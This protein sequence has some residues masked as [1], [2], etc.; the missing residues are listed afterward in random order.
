MSVEQ[1]VVAYYGW[2]VPT[3]KAIF[4]WADELDYDLPDGVRLLNMD[5][6]EVVFGVK[7]YES[8]SSRWGPMEGN[9]ISL[10][11]TEILQKYLDWFDNGG[12]QLALRFL[13][14][15]WGDP[16]LHIYLNTF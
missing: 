13:D 12:E 4:Q 10:T 11:P 9:N 7:L 2:I 5:S 1:S 15:N 6:T 3:T 8:G 14:G 16:R